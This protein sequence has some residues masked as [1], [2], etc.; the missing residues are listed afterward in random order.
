MP[1]SSPCLRRYPRLAHAGPGANFG[2]DSVLQFGEVPTAT[3]GSAAGAGRQRVALEACV[4]ARKP[5][6]R[7]EKKAADILMESSPSTALS[8]PSALETWKRFK[9]ESHRRQTRRQLMF[10][11][12]PPPNQGSPCPHEHRAVTYQNSRTLETFGFLP[13]FSR[14]RSDQIA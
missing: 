13:P 6:A 11:G 14:T 4:K 1:A 2:D 7:I 5:A 8:S 10:F 9:F 12:S 3:P